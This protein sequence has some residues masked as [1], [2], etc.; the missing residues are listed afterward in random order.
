[1][2]LLYFADICAGPGGFSEYM[3]WRKR[4]HAKGFGF[5]IKGTANTVHGLC[6]ECST[7]YR[8]SKKKVP[9]IEIRPFVLNVRSGILIE[10]MAE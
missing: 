8:V 4:W 5:T 1:M 2:D 9:S 10:L 3:L 6:Y 7:R